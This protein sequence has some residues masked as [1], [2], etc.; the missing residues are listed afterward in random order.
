MRL[1]PLRPVVL[2]TL[3]LLLVAGSA[4]I[5][6]TADET[7][8]PADVESR[9]T[10]GATH[11]VAH[12]TGW[13]PE[14]RAKFSTWLYRG[15]GTEIKVKAATVGQDQWVHIP[16]PI[17]TYMDGTWLEISSV[18]F[19]ARSSNG[20][21]TKPV[22]VDLWS[23]TRFKRQ[24]ITWAANNNKQCVSIPVGPTWEE[25]LGVSVLLDFGSS[26]DTITLYKAWAVLEP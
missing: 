16:I 19:C 21:Q 15:W 26:S 10:V 24:S 14:R 3:V 8:A 4:P 9:A 20:A 5:L 12:G 25:S 1:R 22:M 2:T 18:E 7:A 11:F 23:D 17:T 13:V 6:A